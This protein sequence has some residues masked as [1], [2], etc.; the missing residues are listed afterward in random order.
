MI[1][2]TCRK[3]KTMNQ[4]LLQDL[5]SSVRPWNLLSA[6]TY[7]H[8]NSFWGLRVRVQSELR[9]TWI[10][11]TWF[12]NAFRWFLVPTGRWSIL[13]LFLTTFLH[14]WKIYLSAVRL[15]TYFNKS[16]SHSRGYDTLRYPKTMII[17]A[18]AV[19]I[20]ELGSFTK[21]KDS[22]QRTRLKLMSWPW[23]ILPNRGG[24]CRNLACTIVKKPELVSQVSWILKIIISGLMLSSLDR[25]LF[26][27]AVWHVQSAWN[28]SQELNNGR[29]AMLAFSGMVHHNLVV[30]GPLA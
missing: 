9:G 15:S 2:T 8:L 5:L 30:K 24:S 16:T 12:L 7:S 29:L 18:V 11:A 28:Q 21:A 17:A 20:R 10:S 23:R 1:K 25:H 13:I 26:K 3:M 19:W 14:L 27:Q 22:C 4:Q 6:P